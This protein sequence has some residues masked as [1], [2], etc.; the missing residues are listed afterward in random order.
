MRKYNTI[1]D[2]VSADLK[3]K[4]FDSERVYNKF[5]KTKKKSHADEVTDFYNKKVPEVESYRA[6]LALISWNSAL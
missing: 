5:L 6:C 1:W 4:E 2:Q 3:K